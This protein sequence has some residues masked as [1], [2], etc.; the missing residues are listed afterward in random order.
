MEWMMGKWK[1]CPDEYKIRRN[2]L[3]FWSQSKHNLEGDCGPQFCGFE[4]E[5]N[6]WFIDVWFC[7]S[8]MDNKF[9]EEG[10]PSSRSIAS[11]FGSENEENLNGKE[12]K[13]EEERKKER[14]RKN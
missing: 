14:M 4:G 11:A 5:G 9:I 3:I 6:G 1:K 12:G 10:H 8:G 13:I 2:N 7:S